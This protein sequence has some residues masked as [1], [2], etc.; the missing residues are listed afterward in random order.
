LDQGSDVQ[1][2]PQ[3]VELT[4]YIVGGTKMD[5]ISIDDLG[6]EL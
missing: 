5:D 6:F 1:L 3:E 2:A 4:N